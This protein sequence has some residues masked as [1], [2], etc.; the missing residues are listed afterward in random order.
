MIPRK[1]WNTWTRS[2][3]IEEQL[4]EV[5]SLDLVLRLRPSS[6]V[7]HSFHRPA[8]QRVGIPGTP[9]H[10]ARRGSSI[11]EA[12]QASL[13]AILV[14]KLQGGKEMDSL[15]PTQ[16]SRHRGLTRASQGH[17][18]ERLVTIASPEPNLL[19]GSANQVHLNIPVD[20]RRPISSHSLSSLQTRPSLP[21]LKSSP[22]PL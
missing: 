4:L 1:G 9:T 13:A 2:L 21:V 22:P 8:S 10:K 14:P 11:I 5:L 12:P 15:T 16:A 6:H 19:E 17:V 18:M 7:A 20:P 3:T